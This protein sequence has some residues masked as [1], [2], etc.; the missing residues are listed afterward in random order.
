MVLNAYI[1]M[2]PFCRLPQEKS[3]NGGEGF[4]NLAQGVLVFSIREAYGDMP[5]DPP[6][7]DSSGGQVILLLCFPTERFSVNNELDIP[8]R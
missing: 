7:E 2:F 3:S 6:D 1:D 4:N 8:H 5:D